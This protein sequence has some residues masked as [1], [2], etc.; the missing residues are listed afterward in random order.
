MDKRCRDCGEV[1]PITDFYEHS[2]CRDGYRPE[3]KTCNLAEKARKHREDPEPARE[4]TR[5]WQAENPE[6]VRAKQAQYVADGKKAI[7]NRR[8]YLKRK[9]GIDTEQPTGIATVFSPERLINPTPLSYDHGG[10]LCVC[11]HKDNGQH[12]CDH[13][14]VINGTVGFVTGTFGLVAASVAVRRLAEGSA[15]PPVQR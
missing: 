10:F 15:Q 13:R 2:G 6:R 7:S 3:C 14:T 9:Y 11:P 1:K 4:R 8:S 5:R 12:T